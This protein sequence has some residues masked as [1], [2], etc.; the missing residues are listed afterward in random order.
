[1]LP[2]LTFLLL[3][4]A[5]CLGAPPPAS[6]TVAATIP[7]RATPL[8]AASA[9]PVPS[10][11]PTVSPT[12]P[13]VATPTVRPTPSASPTR[14]PS[15]SSTATPTAALPPPAPGPTAAEQPRALMPPS[16]TLPPIEGTPTPATTVL[17]PIPT[18]LLLSPH[19]ER[20][21]H[22]ATLHLLVECPED[23]A[24]RSGTG[25]VVGADGLTFLAAD[26]VLINR[27]GAP[28]SGPYRVGPFMEWTLEAELLDRRPQRDVALLR[29]KSDRGLF[30]IAPIGDDRSL[31]IGD[32]VYTLSYPA[33]AQGSL[34][35][36]GGVYLS[37]VRLRGRDFEH[38]V[39]D[40][41]ASPGSSGGIATDRH[42]S[43]VGVIVAGLT[44]ETLDRLGYRGLDSATVIVPVSA[45]RD[46]LP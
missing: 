9:T 19:G 44:T 12:S 39:T 18:P 40:A 21:A 25:A 45:F 1:M 27:D 6:P 46:L 13:A 4:A 8:P 33:R 22:G 23:Q 38:L 17:E 32:T 28:C 42:G 11:A 29:V 43:V 5:G 2:A 7:A 20:I 3:A 16:P 10:P 15:R 37:R 35:L 34:A 24:I 36:T 41:L 30:A 26:H 31:E 14:A